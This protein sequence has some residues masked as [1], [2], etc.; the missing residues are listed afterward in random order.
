MVSRDVTVKSTH[1]FLCRGRVYLLHF[2]GIFT[3]IFILYYGSENV[4]ELR[5]VARW[6]I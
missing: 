5:V 4:P 2:L 6:R 3:Y 1:V